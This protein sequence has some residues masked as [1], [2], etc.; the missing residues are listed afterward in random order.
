MGNKQIS[1]WYQNKKNGLRAL[2]VTLFL[3]LGAKAQAQAQARA[4]KQDQAQ[5]SIQA[6][7]ES[8]KE[9][10]YLIQN[11]NNF[12][13]YAGFLN[14]DPILDFNST[15]PMVPASVTKI[16]TAIVALDYLGPARRISTQIVSDAKKEGDLLKGSIYLLG[17]GDPSFV[18]E[19]MW[20]L[21]NHFVRTGIKKINED[22]I[23]DESLFDTVRYDPTRLSER[24]DRAYDA[25]VGAMSF[26]WNSANVYIDQKGDNNSLFPRVV[27]DP[28]NDYLSLQND[29]KWSKKKNGFNVSIDS[30]EEISQNQRKN[31]IHIFGAVTKGD[32]EKV[33]YVSIADP[34]L[35]SGAN[36]K[37][38]LAERGVTVLGQVK[39]GVR[40]P[41]PLAKTLAIAEGKTISDIVTDMNKFSNNYVAEMLT[42]LLAAESH[43]LSENKGQKDSNKRENNIDSKS[44]TSEGFQATLDLGMDLIKEHLV[45]HGY[46]SQEP[47]I[48]NPSGLTRKNHLSAKEL[49]QAL[50]KAQGN[51]KIYGDFLSSLP[52]G[53]TD[54]TLKK[55]F[56]HPDLKD[57]IRA[58]TG[59]IDGVT[60]LAG[61]YQGKS[62]Q[63]VP[64]AF[65]YNG[66][67]DP[68]KIRDLFD[69]LI[70][71][72]INQDEL[73]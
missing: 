39:K 15:A 51:I 54:G 73:K 6:A 35:W 50:S 5:K 65:I 20:V 72:L 8:G 60:S 62:G 46:S 61:Y 21:V 12:S 66:S 22:I 29:L 9:F 48:I 32:V 44:K 58:K 17:G 11:K 33:M 47:N 1:F 28:E 19:N 30:S 67:Q 3:L 34:A 63:H 68:S 69:T 55:R 59:Y 31:K 13:M 36:L 49:W 26:N 24:V 45:K 57:K 23:V 14:Q 37:R 64:F 70:E 52:S 4:Q 7:I 18:S 71:K 41:P 10:K 56:L 40:P 16:L 2:F 53:G 25:P 42:K 43:K 27:L 38:F